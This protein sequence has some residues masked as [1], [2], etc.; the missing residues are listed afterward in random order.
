MAADYGA[1]IVM[2]H[3]R[4][5][6]EIM[7]EHIDF[8]DVIKEVSK[9]LASSVEDALKAEIP[10]HKIIIDPGIGFGK[11]AEQSALLMSKAGEIAADLGYPVLVGPS[12]KSF[13]GKLTGA[14]VENRLSG[15]AVSCVL[16]WLAGAH[17]F[18]VHQVNEIRQ[19]FIIATEMLKSLSL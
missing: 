17:I 13:I 4:D 19:A 14:P 12:N 7:Q 5:M 1:A 18:R 3:M 11:T 9:E 16:S 15:T 2:G 10:P 8:T 6:P